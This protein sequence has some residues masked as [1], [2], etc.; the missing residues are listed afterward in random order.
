MNIAVTNRVFIFKKS[1][2]FY[3]PDPMRGQLICPN[4][5]HTRKFSLSN[6]IYDLNQHLTTFKYYFP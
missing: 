3:S 2:S 6:I 5:P 4:P 1:Q